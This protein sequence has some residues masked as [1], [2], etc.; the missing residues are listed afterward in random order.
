MNLVHVFL[1][2]L[3]LISA[4][5]AYEIVQANNKNESYRAMSDQ[6]KRYYG[7][8]ADQR[9]LNEALDRAGVRRD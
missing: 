5:I 6:D 1:A 3:L 7:Q 9:R 4:F 8:S 2:A